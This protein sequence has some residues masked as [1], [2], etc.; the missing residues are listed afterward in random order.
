MHVRVPEKNTI[1][2]CTCKNIFSMICIA[3]YNKDFCDDMIPFGSFLGVNEQIFVGQD[4]VV[5]NYS[6]YQIWRH[7][8]LLCS[9]YAQFKFSASFSVKKSSVCNTSIHCTFSGRTAKAGKKL[10]QPLTPSLFDVWSPNLVHKIHLAYF[11]SVRD[12]KPPQP[13]VLV[14]W[15]IPPH[16]FKLVLELQ[17]LICKLSDVCT[18]QRANL[19]QGKCTHWKICIIQLENKQDSIDVYNYIM[20][21]DLGRPT[22]CWGYLL[23]FR[24]VST[25]LIYWQNPHSPCSLHL[26]NQ[27]LHPLQRPMLEC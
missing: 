5:S 4:R 27:R 20:A 11:I 18:S 17:F 25:C 10:F 9:R 13:V 16:F 22:G 15:A 3:L 26:S 2:S 21:L 7:Y 24:L 23:A 12:W 14:Q 1:I 19:S 8:G 6:T